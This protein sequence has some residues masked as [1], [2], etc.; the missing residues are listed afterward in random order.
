MPEVVESADPEEAAELIGA[1]QDAA[2]E[3]EDV[4]AHSEGSPVASMSATSV[5]LCC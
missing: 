2:A 3:D 5:L 4:Q 1:L